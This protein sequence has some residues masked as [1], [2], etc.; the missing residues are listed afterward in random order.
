MAAQRGGAFFITGN[1]VNTSFDFCK[2]M[3][4]KTGI[5]G[6]SRGGGFWIEGGGTHKLYYCLIRS[7]TSGA[8]GEGGERG[9]GAFVTDG[10]P[11]PAI[12]LE[13]CAVW[14]NIAY[15]NHGAAFFVMGVPNITLIN[16]LIV[17]NITKEGAGSWFIPSSDC[18][19]TLVNT[20][21]TKNIGT[22]TGNAGG[23]FRVMNLGNRINL[24][25]SLILGNSCENS[26][27]AI[28][29]GVSGDKPGIADK[30]VFKN[31]IVGLIGGIDKVLLPAPQDKAG[32]NPSLINMYNL[33][34]LGNPDW[35]DMDESGVDFG[36]QPLTTSGFGMPYFT[37]QSADVYAAKMGDPALL[38]DYEL[39]VDMFNVS[40]TIK[41]GAIF[42][43]PVQSVAGDGKA[44]DP[45]AIKQVQPPVAKDNIR[46]IGASNGILGVDFGN[47]KGQAKGALLSIVGQE[48]EKV[49]NLNVVGK[50][51]Y[52]IHVAPGMYILKVE[53]GGKT[54]AQKLIVTN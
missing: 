26:E 50:G 13:A 53:I 37:L 52:N 33:G 2:I 42:A 28:D 30:F 4:N 22:N 15:G 11:G 16:S 46:I 7:N 25:N 5:D 8:E 19:I 23:G 34:G 39:D 14:G 18:D 10:N 6:E 48:V 49:F 35:M 3:A 9:G 38:G 43:G 29:F 36:A 41:G 51:Y 24:F 45:T 54:Y 1:S 27:G 31:S 20:I 47:L 44:T 40:R 17:N 21:M 12:T 32:I